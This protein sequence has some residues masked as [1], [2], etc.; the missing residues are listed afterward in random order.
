M[1]T[2]VLARRDALLAVGVWVAAVLPQLA[3][4]LTA[5]R[6]FQ[7]VGESVDEAA[8]LVDGLSTVANVGLLALCATLVVLGVRT[9]PWR[10]WPLPALLVL[11]WVVV[12]GTGL[13]TGSRPAAMTVLY[14]AIVA[15]AWVVRVSWQVVPVLGWLTAA[16]AALSIVAGLVVPQLARYQDYE[17][18]D[19]EKAGPLGILAGLL[20]S[21]NNLGLSLAVGVPSVL[22]LRGAWRV[23]AG[24]LVLVAVV[25][26]YSRG[27][28]LAVVLV[29]AAAAVLAVVPAR[30]R[31]LAAGVGMGA[32]A[33]LA[34]A[35]PLA[36]SSATAVAN[37]GGYWIAGR[38]GWA[39]APVLGQGW[40]Y[41][42]RLA[43][44]GDNLG[45]YAYH[46][47]NQF[48]QLLVTGGL[49]LV[50]VVGALLV[51]GAVRAARSAEVGDVWPTLSVVAILAVGIVEVPFGVVDRTMFWP[52]VL[53]PLCVVLLGPRRPV[54]G[55]RVDADTRP[56]ATT[57]VG[58][59]GPRA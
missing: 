55:E 17:G 16:T 3:I 31:A 22:A 39:Q 12:V 38:E 36:V 10:Q 51:V 8:A 49:V 15:A 29:L 20:P 46:A 50:V 25:W 33:L 9:T 5:G 40:D 47:H 42:D 53:V 14:P 1:I 32:V 37:R 52:Y 34:V 23:V 54:G 28:W 11:P 26:S 59:G 24:S 58:Q 56:P 43:G 27:A 18:A 21:G 13:A 45:G 57:A 7:P 2:R 4:L 19:A 41:Y 30:H 48:V 44:S 6:G 35:L